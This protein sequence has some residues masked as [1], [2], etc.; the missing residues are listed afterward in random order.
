MKSQLLRIILPKPR[1]TWIWAEAIGVTLLALLAGFAVDAHDPLL[2]QAGFPWLWLAPVLLSLRYGTLPGVG[3]AFILLLAWLVALRLGYTA[4]KDFPRLFFLGGLL[5]TMLCG[6][7]A[8]LWRTKLRRIEELNGYLDHRL[9]EITHRLYLLRLSHDRLEQ[10]L[11]SKPA[12]LRDALIRLRDFIL[13]LEHLPGELLGAQPFLD[14]LT[15]FCQ[16]EAAAIY[17]VKRRQVEPTVLASVGS[18][19]ELVS[20]DPLLRHALRTNAMSHVA[21]IDEIDSAHASRYLVVAPIQNSFG[22]TLGVLVVEKMP[23]FALNDETLQT[24]AVLLAYYV[25]HMIAAEAAMP[26]REVLPDCPPMFA[27]EVLKLARI[28]RDTGVASYIVALAFSPHPKQQDMYMMVKRM[29]RGLDLTWEIEEAGTRIMLT[30]MPLSGQTAAEGY[31]AR[32]EHSLQDQFGGNFSD[33]RIRP[34]STSVGVGA[35]PLLV[36]DLVARCRNSLGL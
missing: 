32:I 23:F 12:T 25:D 22:Q 34:Y 11:I 6:E 7:Y 20:D 26:I 21:E 1:P 27:E 30:L 33:C 3:S 9:E 15:Q 10:N 8:G 19:G 13:S 17:R 36:Q 35:A 4:E 29:Q 16:M 5:A 2:T 31:L 28:E 18:I 24:L 14:F